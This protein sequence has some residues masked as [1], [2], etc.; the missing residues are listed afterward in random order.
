MTPSQSVSARMASTARRSSARSPVPRPTRRTPHRPASAA[1]T[2]DCLHAHVVL[3]VATLRDASALVGADAAI[4][5]D[6]VLREPGPLPHLAARLNVIAGAQVLGGGRVAERGG[7]D[8]VGEVAP[9]NPL[10]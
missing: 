7:A 2:W 4:D 8:V 6:A 5:L 10:L 9:G 1:W 3:E